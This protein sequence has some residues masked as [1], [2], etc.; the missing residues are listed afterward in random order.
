MTFLNSIS[1]HWRVKGWTIVALKQIR[2]TMI[3]EI[4]F[5]SGDDGSFFL[6]LKWSISK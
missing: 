6:R 4:A 2:Y 1:K 3:G 5:Q